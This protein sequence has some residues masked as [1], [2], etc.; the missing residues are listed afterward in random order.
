M[1]LTLIKKNNELIKDLILYG[2]IELN[3]YVFNFKYYENALSIDTEDEINILHLLNLSEYIDDVK[4]LIKNIKN[5][6]INSNINKLKIIII[7]RSKILKEDIL[8]YIKNVNFDKEIKILINLII[9]IDSDVFYKSIFNKLNYNK[10]YHRNLN[11][12]NYDGIIFNKEFLSS[13]TILTTDS[14]KK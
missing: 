9:L 14:T 2:D 11:V 13:N 3:D 10:V 6:E 12:Y 1:I 5:D 7:N 4:K 8:A